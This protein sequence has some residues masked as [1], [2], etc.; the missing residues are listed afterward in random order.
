MKRFDGPDALLMFQKMR[1][2]L[3]RKLL[4]LLQDQTW[5]VSLS[6]TVLTASTLASIQPHSRMFLINSVLTCSETRGWVSMLLFWHMGKRKF[7]VTIPCTTVSLFAQLQRTPP[8]FR[9]AYELS[10]EFTM[11]KRVMKGFPMKGMLMLV[12][13]VVMMAVLAEGE[14]RTADCSK[15]CILQGMLY[16]VKLQPIYYTIS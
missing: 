15:S 11:Q 7:S 8:L 2:A 3:K 16:A 13:V 6:I 14:E 5:F 10:I 4:N 9:G 12:V 1:F